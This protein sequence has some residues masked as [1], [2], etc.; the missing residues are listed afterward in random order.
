MAKFTW[1]NSQ[2]ETPATT[3]AETN[4][5]IEE[6][7]DSDFDEDIDLSQQT[8]T[9]RMI[10]ENERKPLSL[11]DLKKITESLKEKSDL[12][13]FEQVFVSDNPPIKKEEV[14][15]I[16]EQSPEQAE[17]IHQTEMAIG[18]RLV[19]IEQT[20][21]EA[22]QEVKNTSDK[23]EKKRTYDKTA[24]MPKIVHAK[25]NTGTNPLVKI[26]FFA[27]ACVA[28]GIF[29]G[30]QANSY[31]IYKEGMVKPMSC[32]FA[33]LTEENMPTKLFP[34]YSDVFGAGFLMGAGILGVI[35]LF[36]YLDND[37][38]KASRVGHEHGQAHLAKPADH[39]TYTNRFMER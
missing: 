28:V 9:T 24:V 39:K 35:G 7:S 20:M 36:I 30:I 10:T 1:Y 2:S 34:M 5:E 23:S 25:A 32:V 3:K 4:I 14:T 11:E 31:Y 6:Y 33:W 27:I 29:F 16:A 18:N 15:F 19:K 22:A 37:A 21:K 26:G 13:N 38:K 12:E 8:I 17:K